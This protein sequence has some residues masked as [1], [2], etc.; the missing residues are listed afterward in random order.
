MI[1]D[2]TFFRYGNPRLDGKHIGD[3]YIRSVVFATGMDYEAVDILFQVKMEELGAKHPNDLCV[4][5]NVLS[6]LGF[7]FVETRN[8]RDAGSMKIKTFLK[9]NKGKYILKGKEH[10]AYAENGQVIDTWDCTNYMLFG[11]WRSKGEKL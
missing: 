10:M 7:E 6:D 3:C 2:T 1:Q 9:L 4:I 5:M 8:F 11:Y